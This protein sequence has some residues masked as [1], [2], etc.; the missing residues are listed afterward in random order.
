MDDT[1]IDLDTPLVLP[2]LVAY[3]KRVSADAVMDAA[4]RLGIEFTR[5]PT[6]RRLMSLRDAQKISKH[7]D[8]R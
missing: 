1:S 2:T 6:G 3:R 4:A 7:F 8:S 5:Y